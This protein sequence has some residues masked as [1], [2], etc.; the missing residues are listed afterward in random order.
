MTKKQAHI[1]LYML[2]ENGYLIKDFTEP[3]SEY[4]WAVDL[5]I[6]P[7][8]KYSYDERE[9]YSVK[10]ISRIDMKKAKQ[11]KTDLYEGCYLL[12][13]N[14]KLVYVGVSNC[15]Y[16]RLREHT[17]EN[18]KEWDTVKFIEEH[19]RDKAEAMEK[20]FIQKYK[21]KY[22]KAGIKKNFNKIKTT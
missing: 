9:D 13:S 21:P 12:F 22:N 19:N 6:N 2:W 4:D 14:E 7:P 15:I 5:L 11:I 17:R 10:K 3:H 1:I 18:I 16:S 8:N 20:N